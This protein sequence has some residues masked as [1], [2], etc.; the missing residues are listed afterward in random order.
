MIIGICSTVAETVN[1]RYNLVNTK[2]TNVE[3]MRCVAMRA[4]SKEKRLNVDSAMLYKHEHEHQ[5]ARI[6]DINEL[7]RNTRAYFNVQLM[8]ICAVVKCS[9]QL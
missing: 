4:E 1:I 2:R 8:T 9:L 3:N 7:E 6:I 5:V